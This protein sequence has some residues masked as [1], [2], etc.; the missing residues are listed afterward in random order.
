MTYYEHYYFTFILSRGV[1][2][3]RCILSKVGIAV[4]RYVQPQLWI[5]FRLVKGNVLPSP[6]E[7]D[8]TPLEI[9]ASRV[10]FIG[11]LLLFS[12]DVI[13]WGMG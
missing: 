8:C 2:V 13:G 3:S 5:C 6:L 7:F 4:K 11:S 10:G 1:A 12:M 9:D